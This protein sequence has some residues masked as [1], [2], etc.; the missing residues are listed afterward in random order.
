MVYIEDFK[1]MGKQGFDFSF[2]RNYRSDL[3][4]YDGPFG[5]GWS[6]NYDTL[7]MIYANGDLMLLDTD[8]FQSLIKNNAGTYVAEPFFSYVVTKSGDYF[9]IKKLN[10]Q[11]EYLYS[12]AVENN[13]IRARL[14]QVK[15]SLNNTVSLSYDAA[16]RLYKINDTLGREININYNSNNKISGVN[17]GTEFNVAYY[18]NT[19]GMLEDVT[20]T[21]L[22]CH[23]EYTTD[24][25]KL[26][27]R[28]E[29]NKSAQG[30]A[31]VTYDYDGDARVI[32]S[33]SPSGTLTFDYQVYDSGN[34]RT[35]SVSEDRSALNN[36][37]NMAIKPYRTIMTTYEGKNR[38]YYLGGTGNIEKVE[39]D[40]QTKLELTTNTANYRFSSKKDE[41]GK[42]ISYLYNSNSQIR[43]SI[44]NVKLSSDSAP[45][46]V[47][48]WFEY[49]SAGRLL[50]QKDGENR[51]TEY[52]R[53]GSGNIT[54]LK[55]GYQG[56]LE[57]ISE[58]SYDNPSTGGNYTE[59]TFINAA[60]ELVSRRHEWNYS[61]E[62]EITYTSTITKGTSTYVYVTTYDRFGR[63]IKKQTPAG[64]TRYEYTDSLTGSSHT[65][66]I[67]R[68][69][70]PAVYTLITFDSRNRKTS[71]RDRNGH[72]TSYGYYPDDNLQSEQKNLT[73][74]YSMTIGKYYT[75]YPTGA[76]H[77]GV[78][79]SVSDGD[80]ISVYYYY[81]DEKIQSVSYDSVTT[82]YLYSYSNGR[83]T[84]TVTDNN[85]K[86]TI[87]EMNE[88]GNILKI[89][90]ADLSNVKFIYDRS[91]NRVKLLDQ[92]ENK[93]DYIYNGFN[94]LTN[95]KDNRDFEKEFLYD[96]SGNIIVQKDL[97]GTRTI[98][99]SYDGLNRQLLI[100]GP[101]VTRSFTYSNDCD[102]GS[103]SATETIDGYGTI[104]YEY[105]P[106]GY[107]KKTTYPGVGGPTIIENEL[108]DMGNITEVKI[109]GVVVTSYQYNEAN[110]V[111]KVTDKITGKNRVYDISDYN[112]AGMKK[113]IEYPNNT[114]M[115]YDYG[116]AY[117]IT[118]ANGVL[119]DGRIITKNEITERDGAGNITKKQINTGEIRYDYDNIYQL[120]GYHNSVAVEKNI[121]YNYD[122]AGNREAVTVNGILQEYTPN[123]LNQLT[124][125]GDIISFSYDT[126]GNMTGKGTDT[127]TYDYNNRLTGA[128]VAGK[129]VSYIYNNN[130]LRVEKSTGLQVTKYYYNGAK[131]LA[132][133]D[134]TKITKIYTND[135]EGVLGMTRMI[136]KGST[137]S[138]FQSLY[139]LFDELGSVTAV[140]NERGTPV[141]MYLYDPYGNI[142]NTTNDPINNL[143][144][145]GRYYGQRDWDTGLT[146]FWH[147][148]YDYSLGRWTTRDP[149]GS[150]GGFNIYDY[151]NNSPNNYIDFNGL[152]KTDCFSLFLKCMAEQMWEGVITEE[153]TAA[154]LLVGSSV[155][156]DVVSETQSSTLA[157]PNKSSVVRNLNLYSKFAQ[158]SALGLQVGLF[159]ISEAYCLGIEIL[160]MNNGECI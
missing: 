62:A 71:V 20:G 73:Q 26:L 59:T 109:N 7:L 77:A 115:E 15:D 111:V 145:V 138:H 87:Y 66:R 12:L 88:N 107:L 106:D 81:N 83:E 75:Y 152:Q 4:W 92:K 113:V 8:G 124:L 143:T 84:K 61:N 127:F 123:D 45:Q 89:T 147:R 38:Y 74:P 120:A 43:A 34:Y 155:V 86:S 116:T 95:E 64:A 67:Y 76:E 55:K 94:R 16:K 24:G 46:A 153:D 21:N 32:E 79:H 99:Y 3:R 19:T 148:W 154:G 157:F 13:G 29:E 156:A 28:Q 146:Y 85:S 140:M 35:Y 98:S 78:L 100:S 122:D 139:Y 70:T 22:L 141:Q 40:A 82:S 49:D 112:K 53:D 128:S 37:I 39:E 41:T 131:L 126:N 23:Y 11:K 27:S 10:E 80:K 9:T 54:V 14:V 118:K 57:T 117:R 135:D 101:G 30:Y 149:I 31:W 91:G 52:Q 105:T 42:E 50:S 63:V 2:T 96:K 125:A 72:I 58:M 151:V 102:C 60:D 51:M 114:K 44:T 121:I 159:M 97:N 110:W 68:E 65:L 119:D 17:Y 136:Y 137:L 129:V 133:G 5:Q 130:D 90:Y 144:F 1:F 6:H 25:R 132:E 69:S 104:G 160:A 47:T 56:S 134:G 103:K 150:C 18:Y 108:D 158:N 33:S 48:V 142:T 93:T 36:Q